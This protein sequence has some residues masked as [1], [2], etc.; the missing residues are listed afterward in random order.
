MA[1]RGSP[2]YVGPASVAGL[3]AGIAGLSLGAGF[4][5]VAGDV[6]HD[7]QP[8][9]GRGNHAQAHTARRGEQLERRHATACNRKGGTSPPLVRSSMAA[10]T[11]YPGCGNVTSKYS[12]LGARGSIVTSFFRPLTVTPPSRLRSKLVFCRDDG[13]PLTLRQLL[14]TLRLAC[15]R[16]GLRRL[17]WHDMRHSFGSQL[18][19]ARTAT[20]TAVE[21]HRSGDGRGG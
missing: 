6:A 10:P 4:A 19:M 17:R 11:S 7:L 21:T 3:L 9:R 8:H 12:L 16:A 18:A 20:A 14:T 2:V 13:S 1:G 15:R 5:G